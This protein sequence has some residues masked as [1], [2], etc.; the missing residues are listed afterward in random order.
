[1]REGST[2]TPTRTIAQE[3]QSHGFKTGEWINFA[4]EV[5]FTNDDL[6]LSNVYQS[7]RIDGPGAGVD[8]EIEH[9]E[10]R[11]PPEGTYPS[12]DNVCFD[13][14][15]GNNDAD[16]VA[17]NPFP[18]KARDDDDVL[19]DVRTDASGTFNYFAVS[20]RSQSY[21]GIS[22]WPAPGCIQKD[23]VYRYVCYP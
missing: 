13:L 2:S 15:P 18:F 3:R 4:E 1:M 9:F 11:L 19:L 20:G 23:A 7:L 14:I 10:L 16:E 12:V 21:E 17:Y 22:W 6:N 5:Y 8:I